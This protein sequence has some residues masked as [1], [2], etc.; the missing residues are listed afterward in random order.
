MGG[1]GAREAIAL[2]LAFRGQRTDLACEV[3][4]AVPTAPFLAELVGALPG[5]D[6]AQ[7]VVE[8]TGEPL[9]DGPVGASGLRSGDVLVLGGPAPR[10][11]AGRWL[12]VITGPAAGER[13][14][15]APGRTVLGRDTL[16]GGLP[17]GDQ[18]VSATHAEVHDGR[19][20]VDQRS[21]N[22]TTVNGLPVADTTLA[23]GDVVDI[24]TTSLVVC[25]PVE[26]TGG[27]DG[28]TVP[29]ARTPAPDPPQPDEVLRLPAPPPPRPEPRLRLAYVILPPLAMAALFLLVSRDPRSLLWVV[30]MP[31]MQ[32][33]R[34]QEQKARNK[35]DFAQQ[36][37]AYAETL[38]DA[39]RAAA[40]ASDKTA[41]W[42]SRTWPSGAA[43]VGAAVGLNQ[44]L[45][46]RRPASAS[47]LDIMVGLADL[48]A[49]C[50]VVVPPGQGEPQRATA[51][52]LVAEFSV[53]PAAPVAM[54]L[55]EH[56]VIGIAGDGEAAAALVRSVVLQLAALHSPED[57]A[58][59][60][61]D[62]DD[63]S[64]LDWVRWLPH[65]GGGAPEIAVHQLAQ[66][67][68][69]R[70]LGMAQRIRETRAASAA[71]DD[72]RHVVLVAEVDRLTAAPLDDLIKGSAD[73]SMS[74]ILLAPSERELGSSPNAHVTVASDGSAT[75]A[76]PGRDTVHLTV[77]GVPAS[78]AEMAARHLTA[79]RD[80]GG[81]GVSRALPRIAHL[82]DE[83]PGVA[84]PATVERRWTERHGVLRA[85]IGSMAGEEVLEVDPV[86]D[87][88]HTLVVGVTQAGKSELL[89]TLI[90]SLAARHSPD[91]LNI[92]LIDYKG[93]ATVTG[94]RGLP[95][96]VGALTDRSDPTSTARVLR[97][98]V[99][100]LK[101]RT[102]AL[103][104]AGVSS[105]TELEHL[106]PDV[107]MPRLLV[108]VDE[109]AHVKE[110]SPDFISVFRNVTSRG[111]SLGVHLVVATQLP[112][113]IDKEVLGNTSLKLVLRLTRAE[114]SS[115]ILGGRGAEEIPA[116]ARGR[117]FAVLGEARPVRFQSLYLGRR[118]DPDDAEVATV[119]RWPFGQPRPDAGGP[120]S[121]G[122]GESDLEVVV[123]AI[124]A[125]WK[126][127]DR[128]S[129]PVPPAPP[130][131]VPLDELVAERSAEPVADRGLR[132]P[133]GVVDE[134][135]RDA[136][137][138]P[139]LLDV[140]LEDLATCVVFGPPKS[141]RTTVLRTFAAAAAQLF[142]PA[143]LVLYGIDLQ[144]GELAD[145]EAYP[146]CGGVAHGRD[147][148]DVQELSRFLLAIADDR[149]TAGAREPRIVVLVDD[150][151]SLQTLLA[152]TH[153]QDL[154]QGWEDL[155][156]Q[157]AGLG[158]HVLATAD[159]PHHTTIRQFGGHLYLRLEAV[160]TA[161]PVAPQ[162]HHDLTRPGR[163][164]SADGR[165]F[166]AAWTAGPTDHRSGTIPDRMRYARLSPDLARAATPVAEPG[167]PDV[168]VGIDERRRPVTVDLSMPYLYV[169]GPNRSGRTTALA[170]IAAQVQRAR[171]DAELHLLSAFGPVPDGITWHETS[172]GRED[173]GAHA[174]RLRERYMGDPV[175]D[176]VILFDD[177]DESR[178]TG[179]PQE[180]VMYDL[181]TLAGRTGAL[182]VATSRP[183]SLMTATQASPLGP[184][185]HGRRGLVLWPDRDV[186]GT[187][188]LPRSA[189]LETGP[190]APG[191]RGVATWLSP[192]LPI[193]VAKLLAPPP[194][195]R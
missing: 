89:H 87:G 81:R 53:D 33:A 150:H 163:G 180:R 41:I 76:A 151:A 51:E 90:V 158:I 142:D 71:I 40:A 93:G 43:A 85:P 6:P 193:Q 100:E 102:D 35:G 56:H 153:M 169:V 80:R 50:P 106:R 34:S 72:E 73:L 45:W 166:Q 187:M 54:S 21:R 1:Q 48:P 179:S 159:R 174:G 133:I 146:H 125:A 57:L 127:P 96:L 194:A 18:T 59:G 58:I 42:M 123:R 119:V 17:L 2:T 22:G 136:G 104:R 114:D 182:V 117:G 77:R 62:P 84:D 144:R 132:V 94:L 25:G 11:V 79:V 19:R 69:K 171:P 170:T 130:E 161:A 110:E 75:L 99:D 129:S 173:V 47:Y 131:R 97:A 143:E 67:D 5:A 122:H 124:G 156:R 32:L 91:R 189:S 177:L 78:S 139:R 10:P 126:R 165:M 135:D 26:A 107:V 23:V 66:H 3:D 134:L 70:S 68:P 116:S 154:R 88:P 95:H 12:E 185:R 172:I 181:V 55:S 15:L 175:P 20:L 64:G 168:V 162:P 155:L 121:P 27:V 9:R 112:G 118:T 195:P 137:L 145:V 49:R 138:R 176:A 30:L 109:L 188:G 160:G 39:R 74:F 103:G 13:L 140:D 52:E 61:I 29:F 7:A 167:A 105:I 36:E 31:V 192:V 152:P 24:G 128:P 184:I 190:N 38:A 115:T 44:V 4:P 178:T 111:A 157:G 149:R 186:L 141:G 8:R 63:R 86:L 147:P 65:A 16:V 83:V 183:Q 113:S 82:R 37:T 120:S 46:R 148:G 28:L 98:I 60:I 14:V 92:Y 108:I 101:R 191:G 164:L